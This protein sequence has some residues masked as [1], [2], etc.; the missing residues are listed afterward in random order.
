MNTCVIMCQKPWS[1]CYEMIQQSLGKLTEQFYLTT[2]WKMQEE[3]VRWCFAMVTQRLDIYSDTRRR[4]K[5]RFQY[6]LN[7][8]SSKQFLYLRAIQGHPGDNAID[9]A[10][11]DNILLP[12]GF[13]EYLYHVGNASEMNS[14]IRSVLIPGRRSLK[15]GRQSVFFTI[16]NPMEDDNV[17]EETP[18]DLTKPRIAPHKKKVG[19]MF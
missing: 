10:L 1:D 18:C 11:Q 12:K 14:I 8:Q 4:A 7:A 9:P 17:V 13:T 16:T 15:R 19:N 5:K 2:S 6:C 3:K